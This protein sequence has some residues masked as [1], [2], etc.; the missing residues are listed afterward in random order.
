MKNTQTT[1]K[2]SIGR[3]PKVINWPDGEF[4]IA[5]LIQKT[6]LSR[7]TIYDKVH[8]SLSDKTLIEVGKIKGKGRPSIIYRKSADFANALAAATQVSVPVAM[9]EAAT[10]AA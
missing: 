8:E 2:G 4:T 1:E 5:L 6:G 9:A 10:V 7:V 3:P